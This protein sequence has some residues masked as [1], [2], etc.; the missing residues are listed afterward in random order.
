MNSTNNL[1][2]CEAYKHAKDV[3][4]R[5]M[6][7]KFT[8]DASCRSWVNNL[9]LSQSEV[10]LEVEL[11]TANNIFTFGVTPNQANSTGVVFNT[12][13]R[14][15]LQDSLVVSEYGIFVGQPSSRTDTS[16]RLCT[17]GDASQ[18]AVA[19]AAALDS[20]FYSNGSL[21]TKANNDVV[22]PYR[23]LWNHRYVPQTQ[24][25]NVQN[26]ARPV[27]AISQVRGA[28]DGFVTQEPNLLLIGSKNY[29]PQIVLPTALAS[30]AAFLRCVI[31]YRGVLAQN[32][33]VV[34]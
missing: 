16:W 7:N 8:D 18:I 15:Q 17:Y 12:E 3:F 29:E 28:E 9:K 1:S 30:A 11:N 6:R 13:R 10:R 25:L 4:F 14:L 24:Q 27:L 2:A 22:I 31:I 33:T 19:D 26:A 34:S 20:T 5:S 21:V 23:G 32:S